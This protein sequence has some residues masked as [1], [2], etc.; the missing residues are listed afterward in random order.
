VTEPVAAPA[1][2]AA[3]GGGRLWR[4][5]RHAAALAGIGVL[6]MMLLGGLDVLATNLL[7]QPI[8]GAYEII[9]TMM[10]ASIF[11]A[12]ALSQAEGRQIRVELITE[13]LGAR[14]RGVLDA[15]ADLCS[16]LVYGLIA[17]Y[18]IRAAWSST[19]IGE[20]SSGIVKFPQWPAK[21]ALALGALLMVAQC[22]VGAWRSV[23]RALA[24]GS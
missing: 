9:E 12:L 3:G 8:P 14:A 10:V 6:V 4:V 22:G 7:S 17:W 18:G 16:L 23:R 2:G 5:E 15:L 13:R 19:L 1:Q 21:I 20:F 11:L 24:A